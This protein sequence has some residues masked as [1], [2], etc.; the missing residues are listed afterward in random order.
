VKFTLRRLFAATTTISIGLAALVYAAGD[1]PSIA[2]WYISGWLVGGGFGLLARNPFIGFLVGA[3][4]GLVAYHL[5]VF[6][7]LLKYAA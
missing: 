7:L 3:L 1:D 6:I 4:V 5:V 2:L